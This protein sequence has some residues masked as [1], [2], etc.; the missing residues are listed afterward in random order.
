MNRV[1]SG[2]QRQ[3]SV[4]ARGTSRRQFLHTGLT[5]LGGMALPAVV[6]ARALGLEAAPPPSDRIIMGAIGT[7]GRGQSNLRTFLSQPDV[8]IIAVC[9]VDAAHAE[10]AK[11]IVDDH[12]GNADCKI[13]KDQ[14]LLLREPSIEAVSIATP[15]HWHAL[16]AVQAAR[17]GKDVYCEK[18]LSGSI[19]EG[20]TI[21]DAANRYGT[22]LQ[23]GSQER[24][25]NSVRQACDIVLSGRL[26]QLQRI[27]VNLPTDDPQHARVRKQT[28]LPPAT[29]VPGG[30]DYDR[31]LGHTPSVPYIAER[32]HRMW[33]FV[34]R[35]GGGEMTDRGAHVIDLAQMFTGN[36]TSGPVL[37]EAE[38]KRE[39]SA[40]YDTYL[41][42]SFVN[43][44]ASGLR[45]VGGNQGPRGIG[46]EGTEG[47][48]FVHIHG[49]K[50]EV[51][52]ATLLLDTDREPTFLS[53]GRSPG[54]HR[55]FLDCVRSR[56]QP[57]ANHEVGHR[58]ATICHINNLALMLQ[59]P[60]VW[61]PEAE[62]FVGDDEAN[63]YLMPSMRE[64]Y[65]FTTI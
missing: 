28:A 7:G 65:T 43:T 39:A 4:A 62:Q 20:R 41:D 63:S 18:P 32:V 11:K 54:H 19:A 37:Y 22:I 1:D 45:I 30:L 34:S 10:A 47:T 44:Y 31:W 53:I 48:L 12:Y 29:E 2:R 25:N 27:V 50:L 42:F 60:L 33:R 16:S 13:F 35:Y 38:G 9:D 61:N 55:N 26:G 58:T 56:E 23:T 24:S 51:N 3:T 57:I 15:D 49:G 52:P 5:T 40:L 21:C 46:F 14:L 17:E 36:D 8:Q 64:P 59:R 6:S